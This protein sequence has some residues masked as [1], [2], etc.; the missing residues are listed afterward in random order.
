MRDFV[1]MGRGSR[2]G[3]RWGRKGIEKKKMWYKY[4]YKLSMKNVSIV[5]ETCAHKNQK[6]KEKELCIALLHND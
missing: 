1:Q 4:L 5:M 3:W 2:D 6:L